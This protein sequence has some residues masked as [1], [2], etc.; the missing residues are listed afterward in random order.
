MECEINAMAGN[1]STN[2]VFSNLVIYLLA[3]LLVL[4]STLSGGM[5]VAL[6][7]LPLTFPK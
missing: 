6:R 5:W 1:E 3:G 4:T 2:P 7:S